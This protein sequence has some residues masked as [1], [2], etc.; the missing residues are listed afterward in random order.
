MKTKGSDAL[1]DTQRTKIGPTEPPKARFQD[2]YWGLEFN[3]DAVDT[4]SLDDPSLVKFQTE[5]GSKDQNST[6][7]RYV[8]IR[9]SHEEVRKLI[10]VLQSIVGES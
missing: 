7:R 10:A 5:L 8:N 4:E 6:G 1:R 9:L 2:W 3:V